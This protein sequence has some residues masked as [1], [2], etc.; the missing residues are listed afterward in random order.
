MR[1]KKFAVLLK[2]YADRYAEVENKIDDEINKLSIKQLKELIAAC[3]EPTQ[4][5]CWWATYNVAPIVKMY[6]QYH[7][8]NKEKA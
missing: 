8:R 2:P 6:A 7:L 5:N 4:C 1:E 3:N